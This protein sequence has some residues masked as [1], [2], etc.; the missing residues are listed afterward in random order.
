MPSNGVEL[1]R[2]V[3]DYDARLAQQGICQ[4][5]ELVKHV[6][7]AGIKAGHEPDLATWSGPAI[8]LAVEEVRAFEACLRQQKNERKEVA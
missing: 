4:A 5:G 1:Q 7:Q 2:R 8:A 6:V 3:H